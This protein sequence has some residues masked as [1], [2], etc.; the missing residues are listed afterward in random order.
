MSLR[1]DVI[2]THANQAN[3]KR[4]IY[5]AQETTAMR[6]QTIATILEGFSHLPNVV[7]TRGR[8][9]GR[10]YSGYETGITLIN[11]TPVTIFLGV[12]NNRIYEGKSVTLTLGEPALVAA[13]SQDLHNANG[14]EKTYGRRFLFHPHT[15]KIFYAPNDA[16]RL[17]SLE[18]NVDDPLLSQIFAA[19]SSHLEK[20]SRD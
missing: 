18:G 9:F 16:A 2:R 17:T 8:I 11:H 3:E 12:K 20:L 1:P 15:L 19:A 4:K 10:A 7:E 5:Q 6:I 14:H 13:V